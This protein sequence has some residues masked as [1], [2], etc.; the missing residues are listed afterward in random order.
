M[1]LF[2]VYSRNVPPSLYT[3]GV[4]HVFGHADGLS[5]AVP[6]IVLCGNF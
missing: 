6:I 1:K 4:W 2:D 5:G 3:N